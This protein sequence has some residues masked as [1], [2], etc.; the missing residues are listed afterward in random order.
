[1]QPEAGSVPS[2]RLPPTLLDLDRDD[3]SAW[4]VE[5]GQPAYR[6]PQ[7]HQWLQHHL[8]PDT[9]TMTSLPKAFR[10]TIDAEITL[11]PLEP[12]TELVTDNGDTVKTLYRT[13][14]GLLVETVLM[15]YRDRTTVCVSCQVGCAV[16]C[17]FCATGIGGL[18][19]NLTAGEMVSQVIRSARLAAARDRSLT[20]I[21][22]MG[23]GEPFQNYSESLRFCRLI[24]DPEGLNIGARRITI[25]TSGIVPGIDKL[26]ADPLQVNL[27][28]SL[29]A[30]ND[31]LR[32]ELVPINRR[33][34]LADLFQACDRYQAKTKRRISFEYALMKGINDSEDIAN[35]LGNKLRGRLCHVNLIP[36]N[37]V[38][39]LPFERSTPDDIARFAAALEAKGVPTTVRYSRGV[40]IGA[41][42][43]QLRAYQQAFVDHAIPR[44]DEPVAPA[45]HR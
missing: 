11:D 10:A 43:G 28:I 44:N 31:A 26:A 4:A 45:S 34:P 41:A 39:L 22:M 8:A 9:D 12:V 18:Q 25:S 30:P 38:D 19:R 24:N 1:M 27:A 16:G 35:Q 5:R 32:S 36:L 29:H 23:M 17:A 42:C 6:G 37:P 33:Y 20:N 15:F 21:V 40:D 2:R 13:R 14:D 3:L 7:L